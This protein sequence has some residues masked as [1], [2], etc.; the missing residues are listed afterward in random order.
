MKWKNGVYG[1]LTCFLLLCIGS[2]QAASPQN[3]VH[4]AVAANFAQ[5]LKALAAEFQNKT[6]IKP[7]ITV[8]S[9]GALYAQIIHGAPFDV[10]LSADTVR[11]EALVKNG[12]A[13][14]QNLKPYARGKLAF[15]YRGAPISSVAH[16]L[17]QNEKAV[18]ALANPRLAPYGSAAQSVIIQLEPDSNRRFVKGQNVLQAMQYFQTEHVD[19]AFV[20]L[21]LAM[22]SEVNYV[23]PPA[24]WYAPIVQSMVIV[25]RAEHPYAARR[26]MQ[27][28]LSKDVQSRLKNWG[29]GAAKKQQG[30]SFGR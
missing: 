4:I 12:K 27:Y 14:G 18:V 30:G 2:A 26:F 17:E 1:L 3:T 8:G 23:I 20:S 19:A 25:K 6:N 21:S 28:L 7:I 29:Y 15:V 22:Q 10:F 24:H 16:F 9:S 5:P 11:P 13:D